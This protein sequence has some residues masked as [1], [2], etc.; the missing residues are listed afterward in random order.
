M[1]SYKKDEK[2]VEQTDGLEIIIGELERLNALIYQ[3]YSI[4]TVSEFITE[5]NID[6]VTEFLSELVT[7]GESNIRM[8]LLVS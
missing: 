4:D 6:K 5:D 7:R 2:I 3:G 8:H 1:N